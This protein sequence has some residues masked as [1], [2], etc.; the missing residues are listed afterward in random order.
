MELTTSFSL[1]ISDG[2]QHKESIEWPVVRS[3][4]KAVLVATPGGETWLPLWRF[5]K[6]QWSA[7]D[8]GQIIDLL[9]DVT[10]S[11]NEA[12]VRVWRAGRG[13]SEKSHK[14]QV[15][16]TVSVRINPYDTMVKVRR[17]TFTLPVSQIQGKK[18]SWTAPAW[19]I[20]KKLAEGEKLARGEWVGLEAVAGQLRQAAERVSSARREAE[21]SARQKLEAAARKREEEKAAVEAEIKR[22]TQAIEEDGELALA[23]CRKKFTL[24]EMEEDAGIHL[25]GWPTWPPR[26]DRYDLALVEKILLFARAQP[27]FEGWKRRNAGKDFSPK[28]KKARVPDQVL[29][30]V[31]VQWVEWGGTS[32]NM[33]RHEYDESGCTVRFFGSK[34][35]IVTP[36]GGIVIKM[37]GPNLIIHEHA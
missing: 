27:K 26:S 25:H 5:Q 16:V 34:R 29:E 36:D 4:S 10:S 21:E 1:T 2:V 14:F 24:S 23:F 33:I 37:A 6:R 17:R 30:N 11:A 31:R 8:V 20:S 22:L 13:A 19:L 7:K 35:E 9:A 15:A 18:G 3:T 32:K 28:Q 12:R